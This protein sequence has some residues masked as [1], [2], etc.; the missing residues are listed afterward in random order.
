MNGPMKRTK[1]SAVV[2][3]IMLGEWEK[4]VLHDKYLDGATCIC[5]RCCK[6]RRQDPLIKTRDGISFVVGWKDR[7][8]TCP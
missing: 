4:S 6:I 8:K 5:E 2:S 1:G 7:E 3:R